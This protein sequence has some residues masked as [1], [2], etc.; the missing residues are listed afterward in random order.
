M[1]KLLLTTLVACLWVSAASGQ[2]TIGFDS[3]EQQL[4]IAG[5][6]EGGIVFDDESNFEAP[7]V[8]DRGGIPSNGTPYL[9]SCGICIPSLEAEDGGLFDLLGVDLGEFLFFGSGPF[10]IPVT[11]TGVKKDGS[12]AQLSVTTDGIV[13]FEPFEL[14]ERFTDLVSARFSTT[15]PFLAIAIDNI[16]VTVGLDKPALTISPASGL[17]TT[18]QAFDLTL[19]VLGASSGAILSA[20]L[21]GVD[22]TDD[23]ATCAVE[24][25]LDS[26][27]GLTFRCP[28]DLEE[29]VHTFSASV[30]SSDGTTTEDSVTW[31]MLS[32]S[33]P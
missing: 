11:I 21:D 17:Y 31:E 18:A 33:E 2:T 9:S 8:P 3:V 16:R 4:S 1:Y 26:V 19:I 24:G 22:F 5:Y 10:P 28:I 13:G 23:L 12:T 25:Q 30:E 7:I 29:G 32:N 20:T 15:S 14:D 27:P 6:T